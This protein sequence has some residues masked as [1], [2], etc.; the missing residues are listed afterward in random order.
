M[1][2][3][4]KRGVSKIVVEREGKEKFF[5]LDKKIDQR[6]TQNEE[7]DIRKTT[8]FVNDDELYKDFKYTA[9]KDKRQI[10][11]RQLQN[12]KCRGELQIDA[13]V[14]LISSSTD[15]VSLFI[16]TLCTYDNIDLIFFSSET[17]R[18]CSKTFLSEH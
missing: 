11:F 5:K 6:S 18:F 16:L 8:D 4:L 12:F 2:V 15:Q 9:R 14:Y 10:Y 1:K 17:R 13:V 3:S 7:S